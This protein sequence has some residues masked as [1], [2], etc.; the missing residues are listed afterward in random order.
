MQP[1]FARGDARTQQNLL[2]LQRQAQSDKAP[3]VVLR[4][5]AIRLSLRGQTAPAIAQ[6]LGVERSSVYDWICAWNAHRLEGLK[7]GHRSGRPAQLTAAQRQRIFDIV[8]SGPVAYGFTTG[9]WTSPLLRHVIAEEFDVTYHP[10][11]VRKLL[12]GLDC[13]VQRPTTRLVRAD[14]REQNKWVRYTYPNL[15]KKPKPKGP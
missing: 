15:K 1:I 9:V 5:Q 14:P 10:G 13:S 3:R 8:E 4:L 11:H 7:E 2:R 6:L 12:K